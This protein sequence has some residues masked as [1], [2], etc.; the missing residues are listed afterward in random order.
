MKD[1]W[2]IGDACEGNDQECIEGSVEKRR[3]RT[4]WTPLE[5]QKRKK[6]TFRPARKFLVPEEGVEPS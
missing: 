3:V 1:L 4:G 5:H 2:G 6:P